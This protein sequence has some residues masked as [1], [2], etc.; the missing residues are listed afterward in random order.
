MRPMVDLAGP[1]TRVERLI[2]D[3]GFGV[4]IQENRGVGDDIFDPDTGQWVSPPGTVIWSGYGLVGTPTGG[5]GTEGFAPYANYDATCLVPLDTPAIPEG[6][7]LVVLDVR[8]GGDLT[9]LGTRWLIE[10][11]GA[12]AMAVARVLGLAD[13][14]PSV[15][16]PE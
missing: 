12:G 6:S 11:T 15:R 1:R 5:T 3:N 2:T 4:E 13:L 8:T 16:R 9:M 10:H 14:R 7:I